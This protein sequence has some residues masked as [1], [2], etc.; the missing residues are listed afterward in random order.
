MNGVKKLSYILFFWVKR[1][2]IL[3]SQPYFNQTNVNLLLASERAYRTK[4]RVMPCYVKIVD[5][6]NFFLLLFHSHTKVIY[7]LILFFFTIIITTYQPDR[8][9]SLLNDTMKKIYTHKNKFFLHI[10]KNH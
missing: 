3:P 8:A 5:K 10:Q 1:C 4:S 9:L 2:S 7:D 6:L